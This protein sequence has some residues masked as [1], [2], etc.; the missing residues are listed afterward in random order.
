[1]AQKKQN[2]EGMIKVFFKSANFVK[3]TKVHRNNRFKRK[4]T[5][6]T[7]SFDQNTHN[8][9]LNPVG[10]TVAENFILKNGFQEERKESFVVVVFF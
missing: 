7:P 2:T 9:G 10:Y 8:K 6:Y 4:K 1:M 5:K 3:T